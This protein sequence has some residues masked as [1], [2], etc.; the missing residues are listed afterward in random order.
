MT[1]S[2]LKRWR[3][4][5]GRQ[6]RQDVPATAELTHVGPGTP[7]GE[8]LRRFWQPVALSSELGDLPLTRRLLAEDLVLFRTKKGKLGLL[9]RHCCHRGTSLEYGIVTNTGI[10]CCYHGWHYAINGTILDTPND[11]ASGLKDEL[12]GTAYPT[13]E[14]KGIIFAHLGPPEDVP[15]FPILDVWQE[16]DTDMIPYSYRYPCNWLQIQENSQDPIHA[17]FLHTRS[18]GVQFS[19]SQ[20][21]VPVLD[22]VE[23]PIGLIYVSTRRWKSNIHVRTVEVIMPNLTQG[24]AIWETAEDEK[25]F[26]RGS[27]TSWKVPI[28]DTN[29]EVIG[30]RFFNE[31]VDPEGRGDKSRI[32]K[33]MVDSFGQLADDRPY[34]DHQRVPGDY[35]AMTS[36]RPIAVHALENL[37]ISDRGV[38]R[39]RRMVRQGIKA[40]QSGK[41]MG[42]L[43]ADGNGV[44][45]TYTQDTVLKVEPVGRKDR[46]LV[47]EVGRRIAE[48]NLKSADVASDRRAE[49]FVRMTRELGY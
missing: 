5:A 44:V 14:F 38:M 40:V 9:G 3:A 12:K 27:G 15:D 28:D 22:F 34:E 16:P 2:G 11:P 8:Y 42:A 41:P 7:C 33:D 13:Y 43:P 18:S 45:P 23:T 30:W 24:G 1:Q 46:T 19:E 4:F 20:G 25:Y 37:Q 21:E 48:I 47:L 49:E 6:R 32:G 36:Q 26:Q 39:F 17:V 31:R 35:D 10:S 29:T